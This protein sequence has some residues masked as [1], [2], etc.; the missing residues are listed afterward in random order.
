MAVDFGGA[1]RGGRL[2]S[3]KGRTVGKGPAM[4]AA[5][6]DTAMVGIID[7]KEER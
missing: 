4:T 7:E 6:V 2:V 1:G 3:A 5:P